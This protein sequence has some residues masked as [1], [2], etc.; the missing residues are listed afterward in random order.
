MDETVGQN[1]PNKGTGTAR[2]KR[3]HSS[4]ERQATRRWR[5][6]LWKLT[7]KDVEGKRALQM[8]TR[9]NIFKGVGKPWT[10]A[11]T[12][13]TVRLQEGSL[14]LGRRVCVRA[15]ERGINYVGRV[16]D[17]SKTKKR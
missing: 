10:V 5:S 1:N 4:G 11:I 6:E 15:W 3:Q 16:H 14:G 7:G 9:K 12:L 2:G 17:P 8:V 13:Q